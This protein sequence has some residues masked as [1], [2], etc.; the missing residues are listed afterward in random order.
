ML[1]LLLTDAEAPASR[2]AIEQA[3][4]TVEHVCDA[5]AALAAL[6]ARPFDALVVAP[7]AAADL[8]ALAAEARRRVATAA[9]IGLSDGDLEADIVLLA[10]GADD[11]APRDD[12]AALCRL[13]EGLRAM[14]EADGRAR[15]V[16]RRL[17]LMTR[18]L[19]LSRAREAEMSRRAVE[20][21]KTANVLGLV[22]GICHELNNPL[23]GILGYAQLLQE[24]TEGSTLDD[25]KEIEVCAQ[26]CRDLVSRLARFARADS[27]EAAAVDMNPLVADTLQFVEYAIKRGRVK[28]TTELAP[29]LPAVTG[30]ANDLRQ[31]ILAVLVNAVQAMAGQKGGTLTVR[32]RLVG[33]V[34]HLQIIDSG[35]GIAPHNIDRVFHPFFSTRD[36]AESAGL[37]LSVA[38]AIIER[39]EGAILVD[40]AVGAGTTITFVLPVRQ[41]SPSD[42]PQIASPATA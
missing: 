27:A 31:A 18:E 29:D 12:G 21:Q 17:S 26:R 10:G 28:L 37:G 19:A 7:R 36:A 22:R 14:G 41:A 13:V 30:Q 8:A 38:R 6:Q 5:A 1:V 9:V 34:V 25:I 3:G 32:T 16:Q 2:T 40:S 24:T 33:D 23:T 11:C 15:D 35:A 4:A 20:S 42:D 39:H